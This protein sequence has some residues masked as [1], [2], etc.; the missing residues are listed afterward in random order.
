MRAIIA[1]PPLVKA[2]SIALLALCSVAG[3]AAQEKFPSKPIEVVTHAGVGGGTDI[4]ARMMMVQ[5]PAERGR[6]RAVF[7][8]GPNAMTCPSWVPRTIRPPATAGDALTGDAAG[9]ASA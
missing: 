9:T 1:N 3:A 7:P 5:A 8:G 6:Y 4:T 2:C